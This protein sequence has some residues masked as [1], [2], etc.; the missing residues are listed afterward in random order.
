MNRK[1]VF[2]GVA[3]VLILGFVIAG[4][5]YKNPQAPGQAGTPGGGASAVERPGMPIK[6][7]RDARVTI[8]EFLDPACGT[9]AQFYP[10]VNQLEQK[11][12]GKVRVMVRYA[13]LHQGSDQVV[14]MLEA[15]HQQGR[16]WPALEALFASQRRWVVNHRAQP[17]HARGI[18]NSVALD[19]QRL[20][21]DM[22]SAAVAGV[23]EQDL[24]DGQALGVRA[25][26]EFFV[27][28]KP[29]PSFGYQQLERLVRDAVDE[30][31]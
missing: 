19:H 24:R 27:N 13:P 1:S 31:Y 16:F 11:Y 22:H 6:G 18:L 8:V 14:R 2:A 3:G 10:L 12:R 28:G 30:H 9:C 4:L 21:A 23:I 7:F 15:A 17:Q 20:D 29:L 5:V 25:T 26:P